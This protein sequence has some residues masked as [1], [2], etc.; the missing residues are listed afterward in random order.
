M[1]TLDKPAITLIEN[2]ESAPPEMPLPAGIVSPGPAPNKK[3]VRP[4]P[5]HWQKSG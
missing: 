3:V 1:A 2:M 4:K 5:H